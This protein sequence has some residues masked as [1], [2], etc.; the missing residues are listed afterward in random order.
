MEAFDI[1][2]PGSQ[3]LLHSACAEPQTLVEK[4]VEGIRNGQPNLQNLTL[5]TLTYR[6]SGAPLPAYAEPSL[7]QNK[8]LSLKSFFPHAVLRPATASGLVD[9]V[10]ASF[11]TLPGLLRA[12]YIKIDAALVQISPPDE[13]GLCS[14][15]PAADLIPALLD[16]GVPLIAEM[17]RRMPFVQGPSARLE[18]FAAIIESDRPLIEVPPLKSGPVE[19]QVAANVAELI[20][21]GSTVQLGVGSIPEAVAS[22]LHTRRNLNIHG[23]ALGDWFIDLLNSGAISNTG[24]PF[25]QGKSVAALLIGTA[26]LFDFA[27]HNLQIELQGIEVCNNPLRTARLPRF[28]SVNSALEV[29]YWGQVNAE[30]LGANQLAGVGG[31]LDYVIGTWY[32]PEACSI[33][34]L[35]S[36]TRDGQPR[37]VPRLPGGAPVATPR[38]LAQ[39][40]VTDKGVADLRGRSLSERERLLKAIS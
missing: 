5:Y 34:A 37:I 24:K 28:V 32:G 2:Q 33:I 25:D 38:H 20:Q 7:L 18:R 30:A 1:I 3:L 4:L 27:H 23:G 22:N 11:S 15:G 13:Q 16:L 8:K 40:I 21:D 14:F 17:N 12:G 35:P 10:P 29:D 31:Q 9:Y 39:I 26:R 6:G 19:Q 36:A